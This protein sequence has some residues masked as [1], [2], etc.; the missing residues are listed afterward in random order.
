M[1]SEPYHLFSQV[2]RLL[3]GIESRESPLVQLWGW[4]GGGA[5]A[6]LEALLARQGR[7]ALGLPVA[8][9]ETGAGEAALREA[10]EAAHDDG[11]RWLVVGGE[12]PA[13]RL[14]LAERWLIPGQRLVFAAGRRR[15]SA[16][17]LDVVPPQELLLDPAEVSSLCLL[18]TGGEPSP[19]AA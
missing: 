11:V 13:E 18:V 14:A 9:L 3:R 6:V 5:M 15:P 19:P 10:L 2:E 16:I 1:S 17:P 4:P 8:A 12:P 7:R